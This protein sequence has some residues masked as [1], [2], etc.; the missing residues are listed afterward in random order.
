MDTL[1]SKAEKSGGSSSADNF[2]H[3]VPLI[4]MEVLDKISM[5]TLHK[6]ST[7]EW[8]A[9]IKKASKYENRK[10]RPDTRLP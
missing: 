1:S 10:T 7:Q 5:K 3:A 2:V 9:L 8:K 6:F 4:D